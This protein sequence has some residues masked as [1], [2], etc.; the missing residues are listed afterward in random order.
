MNSSQG[1]VRVAALRALLATGRPV[2]A[3]G[4][5][6]GLAI[7]DPEVRAALERLDRRGQ[8]RRDDEGRVVGS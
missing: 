6:A 2:S 8:L 3:A 1:D 4:L 7:S 5:A